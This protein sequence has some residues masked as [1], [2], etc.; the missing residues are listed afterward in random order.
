MLGGQARSCVLLFRSRGHPSGLFVGVEG[1]REWWV[2][3]DRDRQHCGARACTEGGVALLAAHLGRTYIPRGGN[4]P[5]CQEAVPLGC[6]S[7]LEKSRAG[8]DEA[9]AVG[10]NDH[11][12]KNA[13]RPPD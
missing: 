13:A 6:L 1:L 7:R 2:A 10:C 9:D 11:G 5:A 4:E 12:D 8:K 3:R